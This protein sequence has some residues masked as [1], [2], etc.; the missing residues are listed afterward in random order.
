MITTAHPPVSCG[1][2]VSMY[3]DAELTARAMDV[4]VQRGGVTLSEEIKNQCAKIA[5]STRHA[6]RGYIA[7]ARRFYCEGEIQANLMLLTND[8]FF[9]E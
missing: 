8:P 1:V 7:A 6:A 2:Y 3:V 9:E 5:D 4:Y